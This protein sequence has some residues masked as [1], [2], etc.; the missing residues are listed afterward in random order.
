MRKLLAALLGVSLLLPIVAVPVARAAYYE[1]CNTGFANNFHQYVQLT[2][3][4]LSVDS[5]QAEV[6]YLRNV[7][8]CLNGY[9]STFVLPVNIQ[10]Y[11][12]VQLGYGRIGSNGPLK[13]LY[14]KSETS[15][16]VLTAAPSNIPNPIVG[17]NYRFRAVYSPTYDRWR[18]VITDLSLSGDPY[19]AWNGDIA[20]KHFG[21]E[22]WSGFETTNSQDQFGGAGEWIS[23]N[24]IGY[25]YVSSESTYFLKNR[26]EQTCCGTDMS[27]WD[28]YVGAYSDG[29]SFVRARTLNH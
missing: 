17:H 14:T 13:F 10:G 6:V 7:Q 29:E 2:T 23:I 25:Q 11:A 18:Y 19:Y 4:P 15:G 26:P 5:L 22:V 3:G 16:G 21:L 8:P 12:F 24:R 9:G 27:Y 20:T 1:N 28:H